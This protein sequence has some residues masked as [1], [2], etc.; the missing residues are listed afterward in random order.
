MQFGKHRSKHMDA[1]ITID[2]HEI[3]QVVRTTFLGVVID[4]QLKWK[5]H[6]SL[7]SGNNFQEYRYDYK[8]ET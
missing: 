5:E 8:S 3:D 6:V 1:K 7:I 4:N 2:G